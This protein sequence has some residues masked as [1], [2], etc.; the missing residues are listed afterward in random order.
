MHKENVIIPNL[1]SNRRIAC[2]GRHH[3]HLGCSP[4]R[5]DANTLMFLLLIIE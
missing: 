5:Y 2:I 1:T 4:I 3:V